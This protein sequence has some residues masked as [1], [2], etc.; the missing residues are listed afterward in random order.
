MTVPS[1]SKAQQNF[2][3]AA[4][5]DKGFA[6][7]AGIP[8]STAKEFVAADQARGNPKLPARAPASKK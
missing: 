8:Q 4:A 1:K 7:R 2:M 3:R 5:H 6:K